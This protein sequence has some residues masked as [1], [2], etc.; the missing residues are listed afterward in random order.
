MSR[1]ARELQQSGVIQHLDLVAPACGDKAF[2]TQL[3]EGAA[4][5]L[6]RQPEMIANF[7]ARNRQMQDDAIVGHVFERRAQ[8]GGDPLARALASKKGGQ[9]AQAL[10]FFGH[11]FGD[12]F[13][14]R[15]APLGLGQI[16]AIDLRRSQG[17]R[18][19]IPLAV[20]VE[21]EKASRPDDVDDLTPPVAEKTRDENGPG[22]DFQNAI[23]A[24]ADG[25]KGLSR[26]VALDKRDII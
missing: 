3:R 12:A 26:I 5:G 13:R 20:E 8:K 14:E 21:S 9:I 4:H 22:D 25:V 6:Q 18:G 1:A 17:F 24:I 16:E 2:S 11:S 10:D 23:G 15:G 7:A 19:A